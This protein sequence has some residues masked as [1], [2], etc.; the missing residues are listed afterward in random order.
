[1]TCTG[2]VRSAPCCTTTHGGSI[3]SHCA[4]V[5]S[6]ERAGRVGDVHVH[7]GEHGPD[8]RRRARRR[9]GRA[10]RRTPSRRCRRGRARAGPEG[11]K[12]RSDHV[13]SV[14]P[15]ARALRPPRRGAYPAGMSDD[16]LRSIDLT[17]LGEGP[18][19]GHERARRSAGPGP[20]RHR[21]GVQPGRAA[22]GRD[23]RLRRHRR[24]LHH[25]E[26]GRADPFRR[27]DDRRQG[28]RRAR[29]P[30]DEPAAHVRRRVP[31]RRGRPGGAR[32]PAA[33]GAAVA[34]PALHG[35]PHRRARH[36][37]RVRSSADGLHGYTAE[38]ER[39]LLRTHTDDDFDDFFD[40]HRREDVAR[41]L[42][43]YPRDEEAA[44]DALGGTRSLRSTWTTRGTDP[45]RDR[46][47]D[48]PLR[49]RL[50]AD[51]A[52]RRAPARRGRLRAAPGL[53][54]PGTGHRG[55]AAH[56]AIAFDLLGLR[57][58]IAR[59]D[60]RNV[61]SARVLAKLGMRHEAHLVQNELFKGEW[62]DE[63][64]FAI[65]REEWEASSGH[66]PASAR[67]RRPGR[68]SARR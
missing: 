40:L 23:R 28:P 67:S 19:R 10:S 61:A 22:A 16:T 4:S 17:R 27:T 12:S 53:R 55:R 7:G 46:Q 49:R 9:G 50:R 35:Q 39:M 24:R 26:A 5:R 14:R 51:P 11:S 37:R 65:L 18:L 54:R 31:G 63:D 68:P 34:R 6:G 42:P 38:T 1:M 15:A 57:R 33:G 29:Q 36:A 44:R 45:G 52:Q 21:R 3:R 20:G 66:G 13:P 41:Y 48:R 60:P 30:A 59:I 32:R 58:V 43:W 25:R 2:N 62:T 64:D 47:G 8:R 56:A